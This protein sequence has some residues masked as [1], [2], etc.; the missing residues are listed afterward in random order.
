MTDSR[1]V[2]TV[3]NLLKT[4]SVGVVEKLGFVLYGIC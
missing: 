1:R 4:D 2:R 3:G